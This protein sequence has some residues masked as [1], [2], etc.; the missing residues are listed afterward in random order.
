MWNLL[1]GTL[2]LAQKKWRQVK[3]LLLTA[4]TNCRCTL[5]EPDATTQVY[6]NAPDSQVWMLWYLFFDEL[7]LAIFIMPSGTAWI[8]CKGKGSWGCHTYSTKLHRAMAGELYGLIWHE[9]EPIHKMNVTQTYQEFLLKTTISL[10]MHGLHVLRE[11]RLRHCCL[12]WLRCKF[13]TSWRIQHIKVIYANYMKLC[14]DC[15]VHLLIEKGWW[16][17]S[18][19]GVL[20][21]DF[22]TVRRPMD[23]SN[24]RKFD[25]NFI[26]S[27]SEQSNKRGRER[28]VCRWCRSSVA[29][30]WW[31][32]PEAL[33]LNLAGTT[34]PFPHCR[35]KGL[36]TVLAQVV[37]EYRR[38]PLVFG[39]WE[40]PVH[41]TT[42]AVIPLAILSWSYVYNSWHNYL[43]TETSQAYIIH[44][45]NK[46]I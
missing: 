25:H 22:P 18:Q 11:V 15:C 7:A 31:L 10:H 30:H 36:R 42:H 34:L 37:F 13:C 4:K 17:K 35:F 26:N 41:W 44:W 46:L 29:V 39:L 33:G 23:M 38:S 3:E 16:A 6:S 24:W 32:K 21:L 12:R 45:L 19:H 28:C 40:S 14:V 20:P 27:H 9:A 43:G 5:C 1:Y 8:V 2:P